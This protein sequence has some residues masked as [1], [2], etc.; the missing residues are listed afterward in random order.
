MFNKNVVYFHVV[1][2]ISILNVVILVEK[3]FKIQ[4]SLNL[5]DKDIVKGDFITL[6]D[7]DLERVTL[8]DLLKIYN[9]RDFVVIL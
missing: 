1:K 2:R 5:A 9:Y 7:F 8:R 4:V 6:K 3:V